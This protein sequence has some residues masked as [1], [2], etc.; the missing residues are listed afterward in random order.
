MCNGK[1]T[2]FDRVTL[3]KKMRDQFF[4]PIPSE[5]LFF[6]SG[7]SLC[8]NATMHIYIVPYM[9]GLIK[10]KKLFVEKIR[11]ILHKIRDANCGNMAVV[12]KNCNR[13]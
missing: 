8:V 4:H 7:F 13:K 10:R 3:S 12:E 6:V 9:R 2:E 5:C 1:I 11:Y